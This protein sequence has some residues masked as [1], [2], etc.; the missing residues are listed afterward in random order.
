MPSTSP[1]L[2]I[3]IPAY[4]E[5]ARLGASLETATAFVAARGLDA[6]I[7][8]VDDGSADRTSE[9]AERFA[10]R[11]VRAIRQI[12]NRGKGAAVRRGVLESRGRRVLISDADFSTPVEEVE[13]LAP[14]LEDARLAI[15]SRAVR[16][17]RIT[18]HQPLYRELM[19]KTFNFLI[20][21]LG[22]R[23]VRDTQCG[24]KLLDGETARDLFADL[25]T[26]G[27]AFDV[28]LIWLAQ[29]R[30]HAIAEVGVE[31]RNSPDSRVDPLLDPP[32]MLLEIL[33]FRWLHW[34]GRR[35]GR[36][37]NPDSIH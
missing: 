22:V 2:S 21:C 8:V 16:G 20:Q 25:V 1:D 31:W 17:A 7:L 4:N 11:G 18:L 35:S 19:G 32:R 27:F 10:D 3:V 23:G 29:R 30:G 14:H 9:I 5:E 28:E 12:P 6:E 33:R 13:T 15:G 37:R 36:T 24:F 26:P 34:R